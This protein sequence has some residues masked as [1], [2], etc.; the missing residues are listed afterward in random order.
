MQSVKKEL[1]IKEI[2]EALSHVNGSAEMKKV[3]P[4]EPVDERT[5]EEPAPSPGWLTRNATE[6]VSICAAFV[7]LAIAFG[8]LTMLQASTPNER[9]LQVLGAIVATGAV[10]TILFAGFAARGEKVLKKQNPYVLSEWSLKTLT[11]AGLPPDLGECLNDIWERAKTPASLKPELIV[12]T[13]DRKPGTWVADLEATLGK[14]RVKEYE[15]MLFKYTER[16]GEKEKLMPD[17]MKKA[18]G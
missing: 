4:V 9:L 16:D 14:P 7:V 17:E 8:G 15:E 1:S 12:D 3:P 2:E 5:H 10:G 18:V 13:R 6:L 11:A